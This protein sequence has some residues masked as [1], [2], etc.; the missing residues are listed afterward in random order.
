M[1]SIQRRIVYGV[2]FGVVAFLVGWGATMVSLPGS[3][4]DV[5]AP[6]WET[7]SWA[8]AGAH[9]IAVA[10]PTTA[11]IEGLAAVPGSG[12]LRAVPV[13][14]V[15]L[16]GALATLAVGT[17]R[18]VPATLVDSAAIAVGYLP[19]AYLSVAHTGGMAAQQLAVNAGVVLAVVLLGVAVA[20]SLSEGGPS[21]VWIVSPGSVALTAVGVLLVVLVVVPSLWPIAVVG[22][23]AP[24]LGGIKVAVVTR[25][26]K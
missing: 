15:G 20:I 8:Y 11:A 21:T 9:S 17:D 16:G 25:L 14:T 5:E 22:L 6:W 19:L 23:V 4:Y 2:T 24:L 1:K 12:F 18:S 26:P 7:V 13:L 10:A 3:M